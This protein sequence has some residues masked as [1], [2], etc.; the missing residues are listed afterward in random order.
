MTTIA[1]GRQCNRLISDLY[2]VNE[3]I[4]AY[5]EGKFEAMKGLI[6][7]YGEQ[8]FFTDLYQHLDTEFWR[9]PLNKYLVYVGITIQFFKIYT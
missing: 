8:K 3:V 1:T 5:H 4:N 7:E 6:L 2:M 9:N